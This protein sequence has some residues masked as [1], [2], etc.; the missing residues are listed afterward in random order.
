MNQ[1][2]EP[3]TIEAK[4]DRD[5]VVTRAFAAPRAAVFAAYITPALLKQWVGP[6]SWEMAVCDVDFRVGGAFRYV[7]QSGEQKLGMGG[8]FKEIVE[9]ER[10]V[11]TEL[12]DEAWYEGGAV[13][14]V[15]LREEA[16]VT[17]VTTTIR[18][19]S[20]AVRD[21]VMASPMR[22]GMAEGYHRLDELLAKKKK[23][24]KAA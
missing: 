6:R 10:I 8:E 2:Q 9:N 5:V 23:T 4:G 3:M 12:F 19:Q 18:Y 15:V 16:G 24:S 13:G 7:W 21:A 14:T 11:S 17:F 20:R 1:Q 22:H